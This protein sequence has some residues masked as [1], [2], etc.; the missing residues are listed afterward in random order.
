MCSDEN[1]ALRAHPP[2]T[3]LIT[4]PQIYSSK[5]VRDAH[6]DS[7]R[8]QMYDHANLLDEDGKVHTWVLAENLFIYSLFLPSVRKRF[9]YGL[10][11]MGDHPI[12]KLS[13]E[14]WRQ[15]AETSKL[16]N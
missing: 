1:M 14:S 16:N 6:N 12:F 4:F 11:R 10:E 13:A 15:S 7:K 8:A 3:S 5:V 9:A 2:T